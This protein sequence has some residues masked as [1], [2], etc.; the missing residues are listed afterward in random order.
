[1]KPALLIIDVQK[2]FPRLFKLQKPLEQFEKSIGDLVNYFR[3]RRLPVIHLLTLHKEDRSTWTFHMKRDDF[4]ICM[5]GTEGVEELDAVKP[6][7]G[8]PILYKT[9]WSAFYNTGLES[10]LREKG[11]DTLVLVGFLSHACIRVTALDAYQRDF[12]VIIARD[13][14]DTYD[15]IHEQVT[16]AYLSRYVAKMFSNREFFDY[17]AQKVG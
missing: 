17:M 16:F 6:V 11:Y 2:D 15:A 1:M 3:E 9:R 13:A 4:R 10:L 8:E 14:V 7:P 12:G 5:E